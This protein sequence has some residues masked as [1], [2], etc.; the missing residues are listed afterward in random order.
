MG[1]GA[2]EPPRTRL[3]RPSSEPRPGR[4]DTDSLPHYRVLD[5]LPDLYVEFAVHYKRLTGTIATP[6]S[7]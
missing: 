6:L 1:A 2:D 3:R 4:A 7:G 5:R